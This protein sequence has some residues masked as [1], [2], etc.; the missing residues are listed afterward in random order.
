[1]GLYFIIIMLLAF[2]WLMYETQWLTVRLP[3]GKPPTANLLIRELLPL[4]VAV[5]ILA[6]VVKSIKKGCCLAPGGKE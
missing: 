3:F 4:V 2:Y 5:L 1:M 6:T